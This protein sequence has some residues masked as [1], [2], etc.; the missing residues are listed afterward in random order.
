[1]HMMLI[2]VRIEINMLV[3]YGLDCEIIRVESC[4]TSLF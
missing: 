3:I 1:M 2:T 4:K